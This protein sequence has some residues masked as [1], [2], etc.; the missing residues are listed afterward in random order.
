MSLQGRQR[1]E[2][3]VIEAVL[4]ADEPRLASMY[5][6]F[7]RLTAS[8]HPAR[9]ERLR[10]VA[11]CPPRAGKAIGRQLA[12]ARWSPW[13]RWHR[14]AAIAAFAALTAVV[15][16]GLMLNAMLRP[17]S[18]SCAEIS[19]SLSHATSGMS[20]ATFGMVSAN[21]GSGPAKAA[22]PGCPAY[23]GRR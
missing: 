5:A 16:C 23:S 8:E 21:S 1:R 9:T 12:W 13:H 11:W 20:H 4:E 18:R 6:M 2:L 17:T 15:V 19:A 10:A 7:N 14:I 3:D 22:I